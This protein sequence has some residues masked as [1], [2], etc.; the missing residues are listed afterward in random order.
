MKRRSRKEAWIGWA[1]W[2]FF[3]LAVLGR[4]LD[5]IVPFSP[6]FVAMQT[7]QDFARPYLYMLLAAWTFLF[8]FRLLQQRRVRIINRLSWEGRAQLHQIRTAELSESGV[9]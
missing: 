9:A 4:I 3:V 2:A 7:W 8:G 1:V 6:A 5:R